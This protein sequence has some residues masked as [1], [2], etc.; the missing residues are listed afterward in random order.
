MVACSALGLL[1]AA[2]GAL[3]VWGGAIFVL[4]ELHG[5]T[6]WRASSSTDRLV[7]QASPSKVEGSTS[8]R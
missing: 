2:V 6:R 8:G 1:I 7:A 3:M 4:E 5:L